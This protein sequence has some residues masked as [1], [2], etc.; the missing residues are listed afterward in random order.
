MAST[1]ALSGQSWTGSIAE[2][3]DLNLTFPGDYSGTIPVTIL[4]GNPEGSAAGTQV[5]E[6]APSVDIDLEIVALVLSETDG[7][8]GFVP[9]S[10][11]QVGVSDADLSE[12]LTEVVLVLEGLPAGV[13]ASGVPSGTIVYDAAVGG[14]LTFTGTGADYAALQLT[15][16]ADFSTKAAPGDAAGTLTGTLSAV[17]NEGSAGPEPVSLTVTPEGDA[18]IDDTLPDTVPDETDGPTLVTPALLLA[19]SVTDLDSSEGIATLVLTVAGL[20]TDPAFGLAQVGGLPAGAVAELT[21]AADGSSTLVVSLAAADLGAG[22]LATVYEGITLSLPTD[23]STANRTDLDAGTARALDLTLEIQS[24]EDADPAS[25]TGVD[26]TVVANRQVEIGVEADIALEAPAVLTVAEDGGAPGSVGVSVALGIE[27]AVTDLDGSE[28]EDPSD[29]RF[30]AVVDIAF[31]GL[32]GGTGVNGGTLNAAGDAWRGTVAEAEALILDLPGDFSGA[33]LNLITVTTPEGAETTIQTLVVEPTPDVIITGDVEITETDGAVTI[34][35]SDFIEVVVTDPN[36]TVTEVSFVLPDLPSGMIASAGTFVATGPDTVRFEYDFVA[37]NGDPSPATVTLTFPQDY[38]S[39][40]P[41]QVL[42]GTLSVTTDAGGPTVG[43]IPVTVNFEGDVAFADGSISLAET[44]APIQFRPADA[45]T[46]GATDL[47]GSETIEQVAVAFDTLPDGARFS[48]DGGATFEAATSTLSFTGTLAEYDLLVIELPGDFSTENPGTTLTAEIVA[49]SNEAIGPQA[50]GSA[51]LTVTVAAEGD[52]ALSGSGTIALSE[53][54]APGDTDDDAT[55]QAP[56]RFRPADAVQGAG[57]DADGSETIAE[58]DVVM[59]GLPSGATYSIGSGFLAVPVGGALPTLTAAE[60]ALLQIELPADFST[61]TPASAISGTVTFRTDEALLAGETDTGS[62][63]G[64][65]TGS[66]TVTVADEADV[67]ILVADITVAEDVIRI[68]PGVSE[69]PLNIDAALTDLDLS[70]AITGA[71]VSFEGLPTTGTTELSDGTVLTGPTATWSG[72]FSDAQMLAVT[73]LPEHFSGVITVTATVE[74]T[75]GDPAG[76]SASFALNVTPVAEPEVMLSVDATE[77]Q[78]TATG[79]DSFV[80]DEDTDFLLLIDATTPDRDGSETLTRIVIENMPTGWLPDGAVDLGLFETGAAE[81]ASANFAA[82]QLVITLNPGLDSFSGAV[83]VTPTGDEDRDV[84]TIVGAELTATVTAVDTAA[85]LSDNSATAADTTDLDLDAIVDPIDLSVADSATSENVDGRRSRPLNITNVGLQ[86]TDGSEGIDRLEVTLTIATESD[87]FDPT[88]TNLLELRVSDNTLRSFASITQTGASAD[89]VTYL[90]EPTATASDAQFASALESLQIRVGQNVSGVIDTEGTLFW[91]ETRTGDVEI[92]TAD[93]TASA[94]FT[95]TVTFRPVAEAELTASVF[96]T[97]TAF[98]ADDTTSVSGTADGADEIAGGTLTLRESTDDGSGPGQVSVFVAIDARTP[99]LDG[100]ETLQEVVISNIPTSWID[101]Q[102]SGTTLLES[103]LFTS[104]GSAP[105]APEDL[106]K[107][108]SAEYEAA[109]GELTLTFVP[110]VAVFEAAVQFQPALYEDYDVDRENTDPFSADGDFFAAD[111]QVSL[112]TRDDNSAETATASASVTLDVDVDPVNNT[113]T[114]P[115]IPL[116]FED[117]VDAA[118]GVAQ[119]PLQPSIRDMDGSETITAVVLKDVPDN[120]SVYASDPSNPGGPKVPVLL[121]AVNDPAGFNTWS[122]ENGQWLDAEVRGVVLHAAGEFPVDIFVVTTESDGNGTGVTRIETTFRVEPVVDGGSPSE[123]A[124]A[125]ED[126]AIQVQIDGNLI[127]NGSNSPD[128]PEAILDAVIIREINPDSFGRYPRFFNGEPEPTPGSPGDFDNEL[129]LTISVPG[130][131]GTI[132]LT[133][134]QASNL[135]VLPG[136][137]SNETLEFEVELVYFETLKPIEA[138]TGIGT[139]TIDVTGI[140]D[141]PLVEAQDAASFASPDVIDEATFRPQEEVD[142]VLNAD[143]VYGYAG[144]DNEPFLLDSR[145]TDM[146]IDTGVITNLPN[147]MFTQADVDPLSGIRT[148]ILVPE[149]DPN[150]DF[151]GSETLYYVITGVPD[152]VSFANATPVDPDGESFVVS[153]AQLEQLTFIPDIAV[154]EVSYYDMTLNAIVLEDDQDVPD[155]SGLDQVAALAEIDALP[156]GAVASVDFTVVVLPFPGGSNGTTCTPEQELPLPVLTIEGVGLE[157]TEI[158]LSISIAPNPPFWSGIADLATLP[159]GVVGSLGVAISIPPG[160]SL[161]A[162]DPSAVLFDPVTGLYAIDFSKL[163]VDDNDPT[164]TAETLLFTPPP[165][166]SSPDNPFDAGETFGPDDPYDALDQLEVQFILNNFTCGTTD[167]GSSAVSLTIIPVA[168]G[169]LITFEGSASV[170][171]D[172]DYAPGITIQGIDPG[173]RLTGQITIEI[174]ATN[175]GALFDATGT[176]LVGT[177]TAG[178]AVQ[179]SLDAA[180]LPGLV[181]RADEHYSGPLEL[182]VSATTEDINGTTNT[183]TAS[184]TIDIVPVA[185]TPVFAF[186]PSDIDPDTGQPFVDESQS[187]VV[188]QAIEDVPYTLADGLL[189]TSPDQDGSEVV[190]VVLSGVPADLLV[191]AG[192][193]AP[194]GGIINNGDGSFTISQDAYPFVQLVLKD[195][196]ARTPDLLD[197]NLPDEIPLS[198]TV[199]TF[200]LDNADQ[201]SATTD[202]VFKVRPDAEV[203]VLSASIAPE[204]GAEDDGTAFALSLSATTTDP[205]ESMEFVVSVTPGAQV[206]LDGIAQVAQ[207]DGSF[208]LPGGAPVAGPGGATTIFGPAGAVTLVAGPDFAGELSASVTAVTIDA[209]ALG[210]FVDRQPSTSVDLAVTITPTADL[211]V[212]QTDDTIVL[213]EGDEPDQPSFRPADEIAVSVTDMDG[214]EDIT[215]LVYTLVGVPTGTTYTIG[216]APVAVA[217]ADLVFSGTQA[218]FALLEVQ[219]PVNY[220]TNGTP[221]TG[222]LAVTTDEG[223]AETVSFSVEVTGEVDLAVTVAPID[224]A[225]TGA[226]VSVALGIDAEVLDPQTTGSE[227]LDEVVVTF[228]APLPVGALASAGVLSGDRMTVTLTRG[229]TSSADFALLVAALAVTVPGDFSGPLTGTVVAESNH[230][231]SPPVSFVANINDQPE[232]TG[233][234]DLGTTAQTALIVPVADLLATSSDPDGLAGI[235]NLVSDTADVSAVING[236]NVEIT[237][238]NAYSGPVNF[239]YDVSDA[240][241]PV[242]VAEASATLDVTAETQLVASASMITGPDGTL[243]PIVEDAS[244]GAGPSDT[245]LGT[246]AGEAVV[247]APGV[248]DYAGIE[249]FAMLD[250]NDLVDLSAAT[251]GFAVDLGAGDDAVIGGQGADTLTGGAGSDSFGLGVALDITDVITDYESGIDQIDLSTV[252]TGSDTLDGR[253]SYDSGTGDLSVLGDVSAQ[254][255]ASGGGIPAS[256]EV[257]FENASG[258]QVTAVI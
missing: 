114:I 32:P 109:T 169:P 171:E 51:I 243:I 105:L 216:G 147:D 141:T 84:A 116:N 25:D 57:S 185:D 96:V 157:D 94:D 177:P 86:D 68:D 145:L 107:I 7:P 140:A 52:I 117:V 231:T 198:V 119:I 47:D 58:V 45:V 228:D 227:T 123:T 191:Q 217:G 17:S 124:S 241:T 255:A 204:T 69:I 253:V 210:S 239:T 60:Y 156:G 102:L 192:P 122:L 162:T 59:T 63:D 150:A 76:T 34:L 212:D 153:A 15:L 38:S 108:A 44:D 120:L 170:P 101:G 62:A 46:P 121:T 18:E 258:A 222:T 112:A 246:G 93:N 186:D 236:A 92:D 9:S 125:L 179:Y 164:M 127:D 73:S 234:V 54:D 16:P 134:A 218:E 6:I 36:E 129:G 88:D 10:V 65:E 27:I 40:N 183:R 189:A 111:L 181:I 26:G 249:G 230:G 55:T 3:N 215:S 250:G 182:S 30:A 180:D 100:S 193:G 135:W 159:N 4:A 106:A 251:T 229:A 61:E 132:T 77:P 149:G 48:I 247:V 70:E 104:D 83:R 202:F 130:G 56:L 22:T 31:G 221:L 126:T 209:S 35:L 248:R 23:F 85:G 128:S 257:I 195:E 219:F 99:D 167:T 82:G 11:W 206:F 176:A 166:E 97:D 29:P 238:L 220:A 20:P 95:T 175:G 115:T 174:D 148:E 142:G 87:P 172:T 232:I 242:A 139:I 240:G 42:E 66:F 223:G 203:P 13:L 160:A 137:D 187:P 151:D 235:S 98:V 21:V 237:V 154:T 163:G 188:I 196:H 75:E 136:Q 211:V 64:V 72:S 143:R 244:G 200:E 138:V 90:V 173:E 155:F 80:V 205:H 71:S 79:A 252:L 74:T 53:T 168:D 208:V 89:S 12:A 91:S 256:V 254:I 190:S 67:D 113:A 41:A 178:G 144:Y 110:D 158:P 245:A 133:A 39:T 33:I 24:D 213:D 194:S 78:V 8:L 152:G 165:H 201:N 146:V 1:G 103:A 225:Q 50:S 49:V 5:L 37:A 19:P 28:T 14:D 197:A 131:D 199:N 207:A 161:S 226:P 43:A 214:S 184:Q 224:Q 81:I 118:G 233:P 2:A